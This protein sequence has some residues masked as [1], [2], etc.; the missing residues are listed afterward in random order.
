MAKFE[1]LLLVIAG[2]SLASANM[3]SY[4]SKLE[5]C[6]CYNATTNSPCSGSIQSQCESYYKAVAWT[7][8]PGVFGLLFFLIILP[9]IRLARR[10]CNCCGGSKPSEGCCCPSDEPHSGYSTCEVC[11]LK[12]FIFAGTVVIA[13]MGLATVIRSADLKDGI[14]T[15]GNDL[16]DFA[17]K[18]NNATDTAVTEYNALS[19]LDVSSSSKQ[20]VEDAAYTAG[21]QT[22]DLRNGINDMNDYDHNKWYSRYYVTFIICCLILLVFLLCSFV[23]L[24]NLKSCLPA[25]AMS[26]LSMSGILFCIVVVLYQIS[27][28][29]TTDV[30]D[31]YNTTTTYLQER[32]ENELGCNP[33]STTGLAVI[34]STTESAKTSFTNRICQAACQGLYNCPL[35]CN[36]E[37]FST[38]ELILDNSSPANPSDPAFATCGTTPS[39]CT[40]RMCATD[41]VDG[42]IKQESQYIVGNIT[43]SVP[44]FNNIFT[45][46][47]PVAN[48]SVLTDLVNTIE[49]PVCNT[50]KDCAV[51]SWALTTCTLVLAIVL[52]IVM[53]MGQK[54]FGYKPPYRSLGEHQPMSTHYPTAPPPL[55]YGTA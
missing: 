25:I 53:L 30:C 16:N 20:Q 48:C 6:L 24:C 23:A 35:S 15:L 47:Y 46:V 39:E 54:R 26:L 10:C 1:R 34:T 18:I 37:E 17:D 50:V 44:A 45:Y 14:I 11:S 32:I 8:W 27:G 51:D 52:S 13:A 9:F 33:G 42:S 38:V 41:C 49:D 36:P 28:V 55:R 43:T 22:Q 40:V 29:V 12:L 5:D 7:L 4:S 31:S 2:A 19:T 21:N 3:M